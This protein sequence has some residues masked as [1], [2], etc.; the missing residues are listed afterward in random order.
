LY[1][2]HATGLLGV[3]TQNWN[4]IRCRPTRWR[5]ALGAVLEVVPA[6][7]S[8]WTVIFLVLVVGMSLLPS[9]HPRMAIEQHGPTR[10]YRLRTAAN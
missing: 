7:T 6:S 9:L 5:H 2:P 8:A 4:V 10:T 3:D 1:L